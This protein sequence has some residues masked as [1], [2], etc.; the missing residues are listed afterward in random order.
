MKELELSKQL[1]IDMLTWMSPKYAVTTIH[2]RSAFLKKTFKKYKVLNH[3]TIRKIMKGIKHQHQRACI[4]M[5]NKY[6][7]DAEIDF[8]INVPSVK[9]QAQKLPDILSAAEIKMMIDAAPKPYDLAI[10]CIFNMGAGL[11][12]SEIIKFSWNHIR[13]VDWITNKDSY[14][15]AVIKSGKGSVDRV[16][17]IPKN[18][19]KDLYAYAHRKGVLNEFGIPKSGMIFSFGHS[20]VFREVSVNKPEEEKNIDYVKNR[21]D[22]FRYNIIEKHCEKALN[23][24]IKIHSLRHSRSTYLYEVEKVPIE[25]IQILLGHSTIN[26][27]M[28][29]T[30]INPRSVFELVKDVEEI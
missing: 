23:K 28:I 29:Y 17:N 5:I 26:T 12:V 4:V 8:A 19:M 27:T 2:N 11:R 16:V 3:E 15:I 9:K 25:K 14:G 1:Y 24:H 18:L 20:K 13:W 10:R 30:K 7:Y 21:Y 22:W 6:C